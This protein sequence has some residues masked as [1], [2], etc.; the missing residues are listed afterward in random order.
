M[1]RRRVPTQI[2]E[3]RG[4]F[5]EHPNRR[6]DPTPVVTEPL[7]KPPDGLSEA[8]RE[9]WAE[10]ARTAPAGVLTRADRLSVELAA[11]LLA[12]LRAGSSAM[13]TSR[14]ANLRH[15]L[16]SFGMTPADRA[17]V[18]VPPEPRSKLGPIARALA[19]LK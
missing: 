15:L 17:N 19:D 2:L 6:R 1:S 4:A 8:E 13:Q 12:E 9:A 16:A 7:G 11:R 18:S 14:I 10:I 5:K 3:A